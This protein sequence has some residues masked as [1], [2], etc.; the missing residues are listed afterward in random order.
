[1]YQMTSIFFILKIPLKCDTLMITEH[2]TCINQQHTRDITH[3]WH[4]S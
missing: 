3:Q 4:V 2:N 1:M